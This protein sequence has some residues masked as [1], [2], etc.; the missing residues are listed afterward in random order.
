MLSTTR[1][2]AILLATTGLA[3][4]VLG[5]QHWQLTKR[6]AN[7]EAV[8]AQQL[9]TRAT[10]ETSTVEALQTAAAAWREAQTG[11]EGAVT[12]N[13][14]AELV[15][16]ALDK[17]LMTTLDDALERRATAKEQARTEQFLSVAQQGIQ[18]EVEAIADEFGLTEAQVAQASDVMVQGMHEGMELRS[19]VFRGEVSVLDARSE[20]QAIRQ[21]VT[22]TLQ[23]VLGGDA[24]DALGQRLHGEGGWDAA[25]A[26]RG[27]GLPP[28]F[29]P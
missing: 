23:D 9:V 17:A 14:A 11:A 27:A 22:G 19:A 20:G 8:A 4:I 1:I 29:R 10:P 15:Q 28:M 21:D 24:Y 12:P 16:A 7:L 5:V 3:L 6:V 13:E 18:G 25:A 2:L 26:G